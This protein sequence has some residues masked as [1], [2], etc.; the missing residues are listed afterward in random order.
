[1]ILHFTAERHTWVCWRLE[2]KMREEMKRWVKNK[3][4]EEEKEGKGKR[5]I[6][7]KEKI[8]QKDTALTGRQTLVGLLE[9]GG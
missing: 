8:T 5:N 9:A 4:R 7:N 6:R 1:M 3:R 2:S